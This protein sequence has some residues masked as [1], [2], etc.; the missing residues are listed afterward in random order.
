MKIG[1]YHFWLILLVLQLMGVTSVVAENAPSASEIT[2]DYTNTISSTAPA[3]DP[4]IRLDPE[5]VPTKVSVGIYVY[6]LVKV[7]DVDTTF[8]VDFFLV[9]K[10]H[11]SRLKSVSQASPGVYRKYKLDEIWDPQVTAVNERDLSMRLGNTAKVDQKGN[12]TYLQR[13]Q[14]ALSFDHQLKEFPFDILIS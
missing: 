10:W 5:G 9:L 11:D 3:A 8:T 13:Y 6:D 2:T 12:V 4:E 1:C 14:G 7:S